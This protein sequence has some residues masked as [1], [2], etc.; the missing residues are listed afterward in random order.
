MATDETDGR[1]DRDRAEDAADTVALSE[2]TVGVDYRSPAELR[3][4]ITLGE[5][6]TETHQSSDA[7]AD[8]E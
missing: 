4:G 7:D 1:D 3:C 6:T 5:D 8:A 2:R